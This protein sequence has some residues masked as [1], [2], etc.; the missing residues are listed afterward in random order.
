LRK[1][2]TGANKYTEKIERKNV[3]K[4]KKDKRPSHFKPKPNQAI[5][6]NGC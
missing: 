5:E 2:S 1:L 3:L 4:K 6:P